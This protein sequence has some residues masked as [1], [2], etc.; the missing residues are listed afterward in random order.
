MAIQCIAADYLTEMNRAIKGI[1]DD[2]KLP[3]LGIANMAL[4]NTAIHHIDIFQDLLKPL[5]YIEECVK[6]MNIAVIGRD[7]LH[8]TAFSAIHALETQLKFFQQ[9]ATV[10]EPLSKTPLYSFLNQLSSLNLED[11][12][13]E[14][15]W[16]DALI[17][18][19]L[20]LFLFLNNWLLLP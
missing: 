13:T 2:L 1:F 16:H 18:K 4:E 12:E 8:I 5:S 11:F 3:G 6:T 10:E 20:K 19:S 7:A 14:E 9:Y 15:D 17:E